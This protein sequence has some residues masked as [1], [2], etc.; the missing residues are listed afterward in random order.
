MRLV[1]ML[2]MT[3]ALSSG[4][5]LF[6]QEPIYKWGEPVTDEKLDR[7]LEKLLM[8]SDEGFI[9]LRSKPDM[10]TT[11]KYWLEYYDQQLKLKN[12][13]E[14]RF[15]GGVMG[16]SY[17]IHDIQGVNGKIYAF[18]EHWSKADQMHSLAIKEINS[19]GSLTDLAELDGIAAQKIMNN[20]FFNVSFSDDGSKL[21]VLAELPFEKETKEIVR[22]TC[23]ET[24]TMKQVWK[25]ERELGWPCEKARNNYVAVDNQGAAYIFKRIWQKPI[26]QYALYSFNG[27]DKYNETEVTNI[28][29]GEIVDYK[30]RFD[31]SGDFT[32][33]ASYSNKPSAFSKN[34]TGLWYAK[35]TEPGSAPQMISTT[36]PEALLTRM[37]EKNMLTDYTI[38]DVLL[39]KDGNYTVLLE[40]VKEGK[41]VVQGSQPIKYIYSY[42]YGNF[43][44]YT[45]DSNTGE[46]K[47]W[48]AFNKKQEVPNQT[49]V[50]HFGGMVY[51]L[52]DDYLYVLWNNTELSIPS[53][54]PAGWT[55]PDGTHYVKHKA[56]DEK[57]KH[58]TFLHVIAPDGVMVHEDRKYGLP[59]F[60]LHKGAVFEM[61]LC[62]HF[63]FEM[64]NELVVMAM[65]HNGGKRYR[66]G[67]ISF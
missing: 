24:A 62:T 64:N 13:V 20:G 57:T 54:P 59:L 37:K 30:L 66:F 11:L 3:C 15:N 32:V 41:D 53:V 43:I 6:A 29:E 21:I 7:K 49:E 5:F 34:L 61:S 65:M 56:F 8:V 25:Q 58:G 28:P 39:R 23:F 51:Q 40:Q 42:T 45:F 52:K 18:V 10:G 50:D 46:A 63:F 4:H 38:Q 55:E 2:L 22:L 31:Q 35:I 27:S 44:A 19:D 60:N 48:Q 12:T 14:V 67:F 47:W 17:D 36:W 33:V 9:L 16:D 1:A 26:W